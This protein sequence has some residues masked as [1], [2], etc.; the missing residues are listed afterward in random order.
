MQN[1]D[2]AKFVESLL[3]EEVF[4]LPTS[5]DDEFQKL[6][7]SGKKLTE[8]LA[9]SL[10]LQTLADLK[11][12]NPHNPV[13]MACP[14]NPSMPVMHSET[15]SYALSLTLNKR[16]A[17]NTPGIDVYTLS[18]YPVCTSLTGCYV[19]H[20]VGFPSLLNQIA[21]LDVFG[22]DRFIDSL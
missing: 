17:G 8:S 21:R 16:T 1:L 15:Q 20:I 10:N 4:Q 13:Y 22:I 14:L 18:A 5:A 9:E 19:R 6:V 11:E 3:N 12:S 7:D 2:S